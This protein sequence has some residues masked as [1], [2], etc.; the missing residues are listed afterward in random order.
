MFLEIWLDEE[1]RLEFTAV[2]LLQGVC[3]LLVLLLYSWDTESASVFLNCW[4]L[5]YEAYGFEKASLS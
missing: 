4:E 1:D 2:D 3:L 5:L